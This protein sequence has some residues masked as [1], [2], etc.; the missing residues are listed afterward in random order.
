MFRSTLDKRKITTEAQGGTEERGRRALKET[1]ADDYRVRHNVQ[2]EAVSRGED[3]EGVRDAGAEVGVRGGGPGPC[4]VLKDE[5]RGGEAHR[6]EDGQCA[7]LSDMRIVRGPGGALRGWAW[8]AGG[9]GGGLHGGVKMVLTSREKERRVARTGA[10][11]GMA[12]VL[13]NKIGIGEAERRTRTGGEVL[14][15]SEKGLKYAIERRTDEK[16]ARSGALKL[17][18]NWSKFGN[19]RRRGEVNSRADERNVPMIVGDLMQRTRSIDDR[20]DP[21]SRNSA[22]RRWKS[23]S[24]RQVD[25]RRTPVGGGSANLGVQGVDK[26]SVFGH[27]LGRPYSSM[28]GLRPKDVLEAIEIFFPLGRPYSSMRGLRLYRAA[29]RRDHVRGSDGRIPR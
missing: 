10:V 24:P 12:R 19:G 4:G 6:P 29:Q 15:R 5:E 8:G 26:P 14:E 2:P 22:K 28:R 1:H 17:S 20:G 9:K 23:S 16:Q 3:I 18:E 21:R 11:V 27:T 13:D 7:I 25:E